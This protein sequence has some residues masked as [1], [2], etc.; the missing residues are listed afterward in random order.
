MSIV[1]TFPPEM[2]PPATSG[3]RKSHKRVHF[4]SCSGGDLS[5][6]VQ[7]IH[8][9]FSVL[10]TVIQVLHLLLCNMLDIFAP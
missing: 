6:T 10:E 5:M 7:A 4:G 2:T 9:M 1:F 8:K 3:R